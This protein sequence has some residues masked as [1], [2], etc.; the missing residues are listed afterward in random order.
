MPFVHGKTIRGW[1]VISAGEDAVWDFKGIFKE[2]AEA[3]A[4][5]AK[6]GPRYEVRF[7]DNQEGTDNFVS[8]G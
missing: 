5:A 8:A 6:L 1:A 7:G 4:L 3:Q 2:K